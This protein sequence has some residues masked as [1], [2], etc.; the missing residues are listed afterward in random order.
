MNYK[1]ILAFSVTI[2]ATGVAHARAPRT[3]GEK[4]TVAERIMHCNKKIY[5][6]GNQDYFWVVVT[7]TLSREGK[8]LLFV[9]DVYD[10][11]GKIWSPNLGG[12]AWR[13]GKA[14]CEVIDL[15]LSK[16]KDALPSDRFKL[17][18]PEDFKYAFHHGIQDV[19]D[20]SANGI[21]GYWSSLSYGDERLANVCS[22]GT[23][24][25]MGGDFASIEWSVRCVADD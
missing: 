9:K 13:R 18:S 11:D 17:P 7:R 8:L 1:Q 21:E 19:L 15:I 6:N 12:M 10:D 22:S 5:P 14:A 16:D 25:I 4:G 2:L 23:G 24:Q 20:M 3:C